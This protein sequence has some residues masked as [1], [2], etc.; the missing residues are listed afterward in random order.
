MFHILLSHHYCFGHHSRR[1]RL[2]SSFFLF[3]EDVACQIIRALL[4]FTVEATA[5]AETEGFLFSPGSP[6][7]PPRGATLRYYLYLLLLQTITTSRQYFSSSWTN[8]LCKAKALVEKYELRTSWRIINTFFL[9]IYETTFFQIFFLDMKYLRLNSHER[10]NIFC[11][12]VFEKH[13]NV[14]FEGEI[15]A[16]LVRRH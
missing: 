7:T 4:K 3:K 16:T 6:L 14:S 13:A 1:L 15:S 12:A 8:D 9:W 11:S 10:L 5:E 2:L